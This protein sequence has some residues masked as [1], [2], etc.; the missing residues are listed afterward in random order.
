[1]NGAPLGRERVCGERQ[2]LAPEID[3]APE[4]RDPASR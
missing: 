4:L 1:M 2:T 3:L